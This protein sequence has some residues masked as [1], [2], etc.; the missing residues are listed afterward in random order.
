M[1]QFKLEGKENE[2]LKESVFFL[3]FRKIVWNLRRKGKLLTSSRLTSRV[4]SILSRKAL[5]QIQ[6]DKD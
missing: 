4:K 3:L 6:N 2:Q 5:H 1:F